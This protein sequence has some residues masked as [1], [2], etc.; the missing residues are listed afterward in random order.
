MLTITCKFPIMSTITCEFP[1]MSTITCEFPIMSTITCEFPIMSTITC[2]F[3]IMS[4]ITCK[5][6][7]QCLGLIKK[8]KSVTLSKFVK[9]LLSNVVVCKMNFDLTMTL[10]WLHHDYKYNLPFHLVLHKV[11]HKSVYSWQIKTRRNI[12]TNMCIQLKFTF[13]IIILFSTKEILI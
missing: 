11:S 13:K 6:P 7:G 12:R 8:L 3:P 2:E 4:T 5:F 9:S 10:N 1:I